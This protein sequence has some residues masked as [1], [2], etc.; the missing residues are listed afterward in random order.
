MTRFT[1][2]VILVIGLIVCLLYAYPGYLDDDAVW[3]LMNSRENAYTNAGWPMLAY[4]WRWVSIAIS[5]PAG[6]LLLQATFTLVGAYYLARRVIAD[7]PAALV[8][9]AVLLFPPVLATVAR[10]CVDGTQVAFLLVGV[11]LLSRERRWVKLVGLAALV[12]ATVMR[13]GGA[14][15]TLPVVL[16]GFEWTPDLGR[17][18]RFGLAFGVWIGVVVVGAAAVW[19]LVDREPDARGARLA[20]HDILDTAPTLDRIDSDVAWAVFRASTGARDDDTAAFLVDARHDL[21]RNYPGAYAA[22]RART[23]WRTLGFARLKSSWDPVYTRTTPFLKARDW[24]RHAA[25]HSAVQKGLNAAVTRLGKT[26]LF[27]PYVYFA[28]AFALLGIAIKRRQQLELLLLASGIAHE[29]SLAIVVDV[30]TFRHS[31]WLIVSTLLALA[32]TIARTVAAR[33]SRSPA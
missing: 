14:A 28:I 6:M 24:L 17:L 19:A 4:V 9:V 16:I 31:H 11:V 21:V 18:K 25:R 5:G 23:F 30:P 15:A 1:P 13:P 3:A 22:S 8:A 29:L 27:W 12:I 2:R 10:I 32:F 20:I 33:R 7:R 26:P